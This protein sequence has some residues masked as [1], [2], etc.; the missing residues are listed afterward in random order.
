MT[1]GRSDLDPL[2]RLG[3]ASRQTGTIAAVDMKIRGNQEASPEEHSLTGITVPAEWMT[4]AYPFR[5]W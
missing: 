2:F 1:V 5:V 4:Q 3:M